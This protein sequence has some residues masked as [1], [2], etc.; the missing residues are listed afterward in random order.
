MGEGEV[1]CGRGEAG[2]YIRWLGGCLCG[3]VC[4]VMAAFG[5]DLLLTVRLSVG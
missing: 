4:F 5:G 3:G 2:I 1:G